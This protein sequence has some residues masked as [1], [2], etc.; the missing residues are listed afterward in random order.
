M[1]EFEYGVWEKRGQMEVEG[2]SFLQG[3]K[4]R[5]YLKSLNQVNIK[6]IFKFIDNNQQTKIVLYILKD[7]GRRSDC[8]G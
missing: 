8:R 7:V 4:F 2:Y 3:R 5:Y 1:V 6:V